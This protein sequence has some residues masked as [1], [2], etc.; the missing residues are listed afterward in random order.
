LGESLL[1]ES[2]DVVGPMCET[3]DFLPLDR[4]LEVPVE[5]GFLAVR[6]V[7]AYGFAMASNYNGRRRLAEAIVDGSEVRLIRERES[8]EDPIR[9]E[10]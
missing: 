4:S 6:T 10:E 8:V 2:V 3:G 7:S 9:G 1:T 5:G